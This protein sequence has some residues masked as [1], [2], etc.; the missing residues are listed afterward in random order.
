MSHGVTVLDRFSTPVF[1]G[2]T[3]FFGVGRALRAIRNYLWARRTGYLIHGISI[4]VL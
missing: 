1:L 2:Q 3:E 4:H